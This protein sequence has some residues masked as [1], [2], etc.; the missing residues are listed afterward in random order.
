MKPNKNYNGVTQADLERGF[1][2][3]M[4]TIPP[5]SEPFSNLPAE[6]TE[7]KQGFLERQNVFERL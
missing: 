5:S 6:L 3:T 7:E 4:P 1:S 2:D